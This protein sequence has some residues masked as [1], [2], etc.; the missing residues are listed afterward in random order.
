M[1][2]S[3]QAVAEGGG[4]HSVVHLYDL[5]QPVLHIWCHCLG[6]LIGQ[7]WD[8]YAVGYRL[9]RGGLHGKGHGCKLLLLVARCTSKKAHPGPRLCH[10]HHQLFSACV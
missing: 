8:I 6:S 9:D 1:L 2:V 5:P 10:T 7:L 4:H 3:D